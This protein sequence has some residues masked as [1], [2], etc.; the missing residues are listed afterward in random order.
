MAEKLNKF[1]QLVEDLATGSMSWNSVQIALR[2]ANDRGHFAKEIKDIE[3]QFIYK[4]FQ[5]MKETLGSM[6]LVYRRAYQAVEEEFAK[7]AV[8]EFAKSALGKAFYRRAYQAG[9]QGFAKSALGKAFYQKAYQSGEKGFEKSALGE[10]F[11]RRAHQ[12]GEQELEKSEFGKALK[13]LWGE[14]EQKED[15]K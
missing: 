12:A 8:E 1:D 10:D 6:E 5:L 14:K 4:S 2:V 11:Y 9:E 15:K 3:N 13:N 7:S